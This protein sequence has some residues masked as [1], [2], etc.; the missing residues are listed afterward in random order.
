[1]R[2]VIIARRNG[3]LAVRAAS[4]MVAR[5]KQLVKGNMKHTFSTDWVEIVS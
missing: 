4:L 1:M 5:T 3:S 2:E